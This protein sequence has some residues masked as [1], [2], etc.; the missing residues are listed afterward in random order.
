MERTHRMERVNELL[1][2]L[3]GALVYEKHPSDDLVTI[4]SVLTARDLKSATVIITASQH[5][6]EHVKALN[7]L[8]PEFQAA[9][10]PKLDFRAIPRLTFQA[11]VHGAEVGRL[12]SLLDTL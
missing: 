6:D 10:K 1:R 4:I 2:S 7:R 3:L 9:I 11:D 5:V 12:E 8:A